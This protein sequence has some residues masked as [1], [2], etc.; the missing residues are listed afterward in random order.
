MFPECAPRA[1]HLDLWLQPDFGIIVII[2]RAFAHMRTRSLF[3]QG[4]MAVKPEHETTF[5]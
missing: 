4:I 5:L 3:M 2:L 1:S